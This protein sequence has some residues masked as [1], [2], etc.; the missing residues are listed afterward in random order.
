MADVFSV[1]HRIS[2]VN[3]R[4]LSSHINH[5]KKQIYEEHHQ[6]LDFESIM[7][8]FTGNVFKSNLY[9][10]DTRYFLTQIMVW[11]NFRPSHVQ[12]ISHVPFCSTQFFSFDSCGDSYRS[13]FCRHP[14]VQAVASIS[15][16]Q[17]NHSVS[18]AMVP[19]CFVLYAC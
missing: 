10:G 14:A 11:G 16:P 8:G 9:S 19:S 18:V 7:L 13:F 15:T 1:H 5:Q 17:E 2:G 3:I 4:Q 12:V 6:L